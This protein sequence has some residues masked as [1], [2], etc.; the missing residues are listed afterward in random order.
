MS[1]RALPL[2]TAALALALPVAPAL[3]GEDDGDAGSAKLHAPS[4]GC[5]PGH[6]ISAW[7]TGDNIDRVS[8]YVE[9]QLITTDR[10][11]G[12]S[13]RYRVSM[14]CSRLHVG[15]NTARAVTTF[16]EDTSPA[17]MVQHFTLTRLS[18]A[19][20]RFTG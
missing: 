11:A 12:S 13:G 15:A 6:R 16:T 9:G 8:F 2:L 1:R 18:R 19:G 4:R 20:A 7:V 3:A 10:V 17:R 5:T 14:S